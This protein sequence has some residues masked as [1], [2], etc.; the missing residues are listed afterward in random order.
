MRLFK[1]KKTAVAV[2]AGVAT[3]AIISTAAFAAFFYNQT[4]QATGSTATFGEV[5]V[6]A[7]W[8][9]APLLPNDAGNVTL[10]ITSPNDN[11]VNARVSNIQPVDITAADISGIP[12]AKRA[13]CAAALL[14]RAVGNPGIVLEHGTTKTI[15]INNAIQLHPDTTVDCSGMTFK[16]K[17]TVQ[18]DASNDTANWPGGNI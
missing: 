7:V 10:T 1:S 9:G 18:L 11:N 16:T 3:T 2:V 17:W 5:T 8:D 4:A 15:T 14:E 12:A 13:A 6:N